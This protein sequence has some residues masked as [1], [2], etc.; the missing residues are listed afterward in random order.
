MRKRGSRRKTSAS[1][2]PG[3]Q[4]G[5][6]IPGGPA[7]SSNDCGS[8]IPAKKPVSPE[9]VALTA[10]NYRLAKEL[11]SFISNQVGVAC[12]HFTLHS[13]LTFRL[14]CVTEM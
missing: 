10:K 2:N 12:L 6:S 11:V 4:G 7:D 13:F 1:N 3:T 9:E 8:C 14:I 5:V